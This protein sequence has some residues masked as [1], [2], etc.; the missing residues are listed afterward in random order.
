M[1]WTTLS[2]AHL[3]LGPFLLHVC[4]GARLTH[5][6][7]GDTGSAEPAP[8]PALSGLST[9]GTIWEYDVHLFL[10]DGFERVELTAV[11]TSTG[12]VTTI[13]TGT[14]WTDG[15][16]HSYERTDTWRCDT[17][18]L[19]HLSWSE[20]GALSHPDAEFFETA[21]ATV[22][23]DT[24]MLVLPQAPLEGD[25]WVSDSTVTVETAAGEHQSG[26]RRI[27]FEQTL[28]VAQNAEVLGTTTPVVPVHTNLYLYEDWV[29]L[30]YTTT[31]YAEDIGLVRRD[32]L[33][34]TSFTPGTP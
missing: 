31:W 16:E 18:G 20:V 29:S 11:D 14:R 26:E 23:L 12:L 22:S 3:L 1:A 27:I 24:L 2:R 25:V 28:G 10:L 13:T 4:A 32:D 30:E 5:A 21:D 17:E 15:F 33:T 7:T 19:W 34:L 9:V 6:D 8:C